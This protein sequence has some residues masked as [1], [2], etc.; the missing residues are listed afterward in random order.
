[1]MTPQCE[2]PYEVIRKTRG[3]SD[4]LSELDGT[5][6]KQAAAAFRIIPYVSQHSTLLRKLPHWQPEAHK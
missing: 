5:Y 4:I 2:G 3:G 1:K 6:R